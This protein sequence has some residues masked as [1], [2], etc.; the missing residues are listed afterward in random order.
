M[1]STIGHA[2]QTALVRGLLELGLVLEHQ[3]L[4]EVPR[5]VAPQT[6]LLPAKVRRRSEVDMSAQPG[7]HRQEAVLG[8]LTV[9]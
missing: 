1:G 3:P 6:L 7:G 4:D 9:D 5:G 2:L 8:D